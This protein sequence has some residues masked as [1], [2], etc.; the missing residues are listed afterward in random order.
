MRFAKSQVEK[1]AE[2]QVNVALSVTLLGS[3]SVTLF[4]VAQKIMKQKKR[5][6]RKSW[7]NNW[8]VER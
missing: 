5:K 2:S 8:L 3:S 1:M 6:K 4:V 7:M